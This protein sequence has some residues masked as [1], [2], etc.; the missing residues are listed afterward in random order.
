MSHYPKSTEE[1][2]SASDSILIEEFA[3]DST[4][5]DEG[6]SNIDELQVQNEHGRSLNR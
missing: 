5:G 4:T 3:T 1:I 6:S 2:S